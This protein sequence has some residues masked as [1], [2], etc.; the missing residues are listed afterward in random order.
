MPNSVRSPACIRYS[1]ELR[2]VI[3]NTLG[4]KR[5]ISPLILARRP[6]TDEK[7]LAFYTSAI[8][9]LSRAKA[10]SKSR[11]SDLDEIG[12]ERSS[13]CQK[14]SRSL[15]A[16]KR[17]IKLRRLSRTLFRRPAVTMNKDGDELPVD[18][19]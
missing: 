14:F 18:R 15:D 13:P 7:C 16:L 6:F 10:E 9:E 3:L 12:G 1:I 17:G 2:S 11:R 4:I 8:H 5:H 19:A